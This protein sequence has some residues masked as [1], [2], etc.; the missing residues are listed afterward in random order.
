MKAAILLASMTVL[1]FAVVGVAASQTTCPQ[2]TTHTYVGSGSNEY[3]EETLGVNA[4]F[5]YIQVYESNT[6]DCDGNGSAGDFDGDY[7][8]GTGGA[9]LPAGPWANDPLCQNGFVAHHGPVAFVNDVVFGQG[10][11]FFTGADDTNGPV[12]VI[13]P[14]SGVQCTTDGVIAPEVDADDCLDGVFYGAGAACGYG[15]DGGYW[16]ILACYSNVGSSVSFGCATAGT[17]TA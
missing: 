13:D 8:T 4:G 16:V 1:A 3:R 6:S 11:P 9:F 10:V 5:G 7:D 2:Q 12:I 15:G 14:T 17:V